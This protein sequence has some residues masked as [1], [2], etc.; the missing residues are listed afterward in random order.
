MEAHEIGNKIEYTNLGHVVANSSIYYD[1]N[2]LN[3]IIKADQELLDLYNMT[4]IIDEENL[5]D[6]SPWLLRFVIDNRKI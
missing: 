3:T 4:S 2:P 5:Q 6:K 1:P